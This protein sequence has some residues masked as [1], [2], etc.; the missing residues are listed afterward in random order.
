MNKVYAKGCHGGVS[1]GANFWPQ[2]FSELQA[3]YKA[4]DTGRVESLA[5]V[6]WAINAKV[7]RVSPTW[8][9]SIVKV[10]KD[11]CCSCL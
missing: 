11:P 10:R 5:A 4:G 9:S 3:A 6:I 7:Y 8:P 1:G 2:L